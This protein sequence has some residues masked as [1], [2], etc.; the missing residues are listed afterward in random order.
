MVMSAPYT[1]KLSVMSLVS[2]LTQ[3]YGESTLFVMTMRTQENYFSLELLDAIDKAL[4]LCLSQA[5]ANCALITTGLSSKIY[6][7]GLDL[8]EAFEHGQTYFER[9]MSLLARLLVFPMPTIAGVCVLLRGMAD[10]HK[11]SMDML[12]RVD[13]CLHWHMIIALCVAIAGS[14][15]W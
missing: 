8:K 2:M 13:A 7:N 12:L 1:I 9:F 6:S 5:T 3:Q 4:D 15:V 10:T 14:C 11:H